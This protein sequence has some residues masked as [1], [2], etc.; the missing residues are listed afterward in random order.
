MNTEEF[1]KGEFGDEYAIRN[2]NLVKNNEKFFE[3]IF[4]KNMPVTYIDDGEIAE[5][6]IHLD[7][8]IEFGAGTGQ[9]I[10]ALKTLIPRCEFVTVEINHAAA[11]KIPYGSVHFG[12]IFDN[13]M[14][15]PADLVLVKGLLIHISPEQIQKAYEVLYD[16][17]KRYI[18][19]CEYYNPTPVEVPYRGH[20][21]K[22]W[23]RDFAGE[24][25]D[26]FPGLKLVDYGFTYHR[27][28]YPQDDLTWFLLEKS[29]A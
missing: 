25:L 28:L 14:I 11:S 23:K 16:N 26:R 20:T 19:I 22:L 13:H 18:L 6:I 9:N 4:I 29:C 10:A 21:G 3:E 5:R 15:E 8:L 12:S 1:W 24:M 7:S 2:V 27:D 17:S